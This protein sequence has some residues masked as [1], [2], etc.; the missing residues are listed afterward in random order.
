[1]K[2]INKCYKGERVRE[3][4]CPREREWLSN[5]KNMYD[6]MQKVKYEVGYSFR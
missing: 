1:M 2:R 5:C 4:G 3:W 6:E